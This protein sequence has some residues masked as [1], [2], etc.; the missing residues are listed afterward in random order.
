MCPPVRDDDQPTVLLVEDDENARNSMA[1]VLVREG[2]MVLTAGSGHDAMGLLHAPLSPI[3]VVVLD[4]H[5]PDVSGIDLCARL[6]Q[7]HPTLPIV[8]V[9]GEA[10]PEEVA[11]LLSLGV[12]RYF[13]KPM[14]VDE[15]LATVEAA[16]TE[17][18]A[19]PATRTH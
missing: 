13:L 16:L 8:V 7:Q 5:L 9:T 6:R 2:Y 15:L 3:D 18:A 14:S 19:S 12:H 1:K 17:R 10:R 4:V 11:Q